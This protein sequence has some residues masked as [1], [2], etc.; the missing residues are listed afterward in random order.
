MQLAIDKLTELAPGK[1]QS[2]FDM[3]EISLQAE[4]GSPMLSEVVRR[5]DSAGIIVSDLS[6][7]QPTLDDVFLAITGHTTEQADS[8]GHTLSTSGSEAMK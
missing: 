8:V 4:A 6:L 7:K 1:I 3:G 5:M 2:T